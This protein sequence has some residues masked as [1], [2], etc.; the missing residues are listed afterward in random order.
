MKKNL[1]NT[2]LVLLIMLMGGLS[3]SYQSLDVSPRKFR[4]L[5]LK[6]QGVLIDVRDTAEFN[7]EHIADAINLPLSSPHFR[8]YIDELDPSGYYF[9]YCRLGKKSTSAYQLMHEQGFR[10]LYN[11]RGG[12]EEWKNAGL[13]VIRRENPREERLA[14]H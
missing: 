10:H 4:K 5:Q 7:A 13:P 1:V 12:I 2:S 14:E 3:F 8:D 9:L 11:L 6:K